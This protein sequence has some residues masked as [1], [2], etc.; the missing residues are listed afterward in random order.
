MDRSPMSPLILFPLYNNPLAYLE[1]L[2]KSSK[3][4]NEHNVPYILIFLACTLSKKEYLPPESFEFVIVVFHYLASKSLSLCWLGYIADT[5]PETVLGIV[6][7]IRRICG[8][9]YP[10]IA[11]P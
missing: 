8:L 5:Q 6:G 11:E 10:V 1:C 4:E 7:A 2:C 3:A 9:L